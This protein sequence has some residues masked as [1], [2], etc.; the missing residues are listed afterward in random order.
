MIILPFWILLVALGMCLC[1]IGSAENV[2]PLSL[3][4]VVI[5][6]LCIVYALIAIA[7]FNPKDFANDLNKPNISQ[8]NTNKN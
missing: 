8:I 4:G 6:L 1:Y 2:E 7:N 3:I 5:V